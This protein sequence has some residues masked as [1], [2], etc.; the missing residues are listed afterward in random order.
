MPAYGVAIAKNALLKLIE[1][2]LQGE[3]VIITRHGKPVAE[4]RAA[5]RQPRP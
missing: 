5:L 3:Q 1:R 4:I 2:A